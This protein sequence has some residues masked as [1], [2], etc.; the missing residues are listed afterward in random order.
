[1]HVHRLIFL[2]E[3]SLYKWLDYSIFNLNKCSLVY[4][5]GKFYLTTTV[6][7][8]RAVTNLGLDL[9]PGKRPKSNKYRSSCKFPMPLKIIERYLDT[10]TQ[11][12]RIKM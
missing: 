11:S 9:K 8:K 4:F 5:I 1:M 7:N 3:I 6:I 10:K 12:Q 2:S